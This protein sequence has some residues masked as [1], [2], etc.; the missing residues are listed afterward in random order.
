VDTASI[1]ACVEEV[2]KA[3][4]VPGLVL[5]VVRD[6]VPVHSSG[7][8]VTSIDDPLPITP[9][10]LFR[11]GSITKSLTGTMVMRLVED[12]FLDLDESIRAY[13]P[14]FRFRGLLPDSTCSIRNLLSHQS[15]LP[16]G[17]AH[18]DGPRDGSALGKLANDYLPRYPLIAPP[19][20]TSSYSNLGLS[21]AAHIAEVVAKQPYVALMQELVFDPLGMSQTTFDTSRASTYRL[22]QPHT[23][24]LHGKLEVNHA[25][26]DNASYYPGAFAFSTLTDL[27]AFIH[28]HLEAEPEGLL[29]PAS[30]SLMHS[31]ISDWHLVEKVGYGLTFYVDSYRGWHRVGHEGNFLSFG[32]KLVMLP[33]CGTALVLLYNYD[34]QF[35]WVRER[36]IEKV[37]QI[38]GVE[39]CP[40]KRPVLEP[41]PVL[42]AS[43]YVGTYV[44]SDLDSLILDCPDGALTM[45]RRGR[46]I[47]L[48]RRRANVY[49]ADH[50]ESDDTWW[51]HA[52]YNIP[53]SLSVGLLPL[54]DN[55]QCLVQVNARPY[56][57]T[58][59]STDEP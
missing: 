2:I 20:S 53:T 14:D 18:Y 9:D 7:Y 22:A 57:R 34:D 39:R 54:G 43:A 17:P 6:G 44:A 15:G 21:L 42:D 25:T 50:P 30:I 49:G 5:G 16:N 35:K 24:G 32:S 11:I 13:V 46:T 38:S 12:G 27:F 52:P 56:R 3:E 10:T 40:L 28:L 41:E 29:S 48:E 47:R 31:W 36:L 8:G 23:K 33:E 55:D 51:F 37:L 58:S 45:R 26:A 4:R 59:L 19:G 1:D